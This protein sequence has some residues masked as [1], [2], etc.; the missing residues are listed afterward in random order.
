[1]NEQTEEQRFCRRCLL[2]EFD[3]KAYK[4]TLETYIERI[5]KGLKASPEQ[6]EGRLGICRQCDYLNRGTCMAC[7]CYVE[8]RAAAK[9]AHC[10]KKQW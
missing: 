5:G 1:M 10:P 8:L 7:G 3:E 9:T 6:Y 2:Q 4:E